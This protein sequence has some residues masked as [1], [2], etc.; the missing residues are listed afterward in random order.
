MRASASASFGLGG[1]A[2]GEELRRLYVTE[3]ARI[4]RL[5]RRIVGSPDLAEDLVQDAFVKLSGRQLGQADVGL[6]VRTAQN[7]ARDAM[8]ADRVRAAYA[9]EMRPEQIATA[10]AAPDEAAARR[11]ELNDLFEALK[12]LPRRTQQVF[13]MSRLDE[14]SYPQIARELG[15]SLSTVEKDMASALEFCRRWRS[16][17]Q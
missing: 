7:L 17:R 13:L 8:R 1:G 6:V 2:P 4:R 9:D 15:V 3:R 12:S 10:P 16:R 14:R 5:V 11:Q